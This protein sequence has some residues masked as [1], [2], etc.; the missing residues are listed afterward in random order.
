VFG[1]RPEDIYDRLFAQ[2]T[3]PNATVTAR[4]EVKEPMGSDLFLYLTVGGRT[5]H[6]RMSPATKVEVGGL[7]DLYFDMGKMHLFEKA[8]GRAII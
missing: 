6:A 4:V 5:F 8:S 3:R 7:L 1:I 2:M